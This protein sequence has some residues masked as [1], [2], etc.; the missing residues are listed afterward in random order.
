MGI[1]KKK[2]SIRSCCLMVPKWDKTLRK[3]LRLVKGLGLLI[4]LRVSRRV[5]L[6]VKVLEDSIVLLTRSTKRELKA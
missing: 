4:R 5:K 2:N 6:V 1:L 3:D